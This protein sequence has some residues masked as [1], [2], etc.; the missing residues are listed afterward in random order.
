MTKLQEKVFPNDYKKS[1]IGKMRTLV[2]M[3]KIYFS[4]WWKLSAYSITGISCL[5]K[6]SLF[7]KKGYILVTEF[8]DL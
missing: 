7:K 8:N 5:F 4:Q 6:I 1:S 2:D 3:A